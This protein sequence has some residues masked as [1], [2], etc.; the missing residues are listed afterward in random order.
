[1][2]MLKALAV[3]GMGLMLT[4]A[5]FPWLDGLRDSWYH[6]VTPVL[7]QYLSVGDDGDLSVASDNWGAQVFTV[8]TSYR[9]TGVQVKVWD[10]GGAGTLTVAIYDADGSGYPTGAVLVSGTMTAATISNS[11]PGEFEVVTFATPLDVT[12]GNYDVVLHYTGTGVVNWRIS[13]A[14][15]GC[16]VS[17]DGGTTWS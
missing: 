7:Q 14:G 17:T 15:A 11:S 9:L 6:P 1:M 5:V 8:T 3:L 10:S 12:S 2:R 4:L 16:Y 13:S